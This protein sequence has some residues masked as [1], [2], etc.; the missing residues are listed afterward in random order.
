MQRRYE[1]LRKIREAIKRL[2]TE[3]PAKYNELVKRARDYEYDGQQRLKQREEEAR[4]REEERARWLR[5][6][7]IVGLPEVPR[8]RGILAYRVWGFDAGLR[9]TAMRYV[10]KELNFAD[11][12]PAVYNRSGFYCIKLTGLSVMTTGAGYFGM[13]QRSVSGFVELL[14]HVVEH[15]DGLLRAEVARLVCLFVTPE[16][17]QFSPYI[18]RDLCMQYPTTP[19]HVLT[20]EQL[21]DVIVGEVLRQRVQG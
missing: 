5:C 17:I 19:V 21:A 12:V 6:P 16:S 8:V 1:E 9:S 10:W 13:G 11:R 3:D 15:S 2:Q 20:P 14:G 18:V 7:V 4:R